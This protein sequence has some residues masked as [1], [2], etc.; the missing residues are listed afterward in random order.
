MYN[1]ISIGVLKKI[2]FSTIIWRSVCSRS[3][4][5]FYI[6]TYYIKWVTTSL[7][8]DTYKYMPYKLGALS[9][10]NSF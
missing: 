6:V 4:D 5:P 3:S 8:D 10:G 2:Q 1:L 9:S 7:K